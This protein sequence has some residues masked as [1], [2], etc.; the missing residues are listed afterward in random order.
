MSDRDALVDAI[1]ELA[2]RPREPPR[3]LASFIDP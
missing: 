2:D 1:G 3:F